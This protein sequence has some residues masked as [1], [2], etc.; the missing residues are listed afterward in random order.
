[1]TRSDD[2]S[3]DTNLLDGFNTV[4]SVGDVCDMTQSAD[5][6]DMKW[7]VGDSSITQPIDD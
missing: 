6:C 2:D 3:E 7:L 1:M 4:L 5:G